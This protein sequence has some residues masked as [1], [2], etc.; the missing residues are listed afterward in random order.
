MGLCLFVVVR[1]VSL[2][3]CNTAVSDKTRRRVLKGVLHVVHPDRTVVKGAASD[4]INR[5]RHCE[6]SH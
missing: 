3:D 4:F 5:S 2:H 1:I 6:K